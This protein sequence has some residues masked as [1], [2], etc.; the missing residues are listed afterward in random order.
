MLLSN[1]PPLNRAE[2]RE[3]ENFLATPDFSANG[4]ESRFRVAGARIRDENEV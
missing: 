1:E 3:L 2:V 4:L